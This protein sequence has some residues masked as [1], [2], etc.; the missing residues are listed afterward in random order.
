MPL[1]NSQYDSIRRKYE[2]RQA[3]NRRIMEERRAFVYEHVTGYKELDESV[4]SVSM[5]MGRKKLNGDDNALE[6]LH[7]LLE[8]LK[9]M[10]K[11][12]LKGA[13]LPEDYLTP[14]YACPDCKDT[15]YINGAK[16]HCFCQEIINLLYQQSNIRDLLVDNNFNNLSLKY[17]EG[18]DLD[19][20][21]AAA[22]ASKDMCEHF[23]EGPHNMMFYGTVGTGK[24]FLSGCIAGEV[25]KQGASVLYYSALSLFETIASQAFEHKSHEDLYNFYD[26]LYNCDLL[27]IDDLGTETTNS[28]VSSQLF[29]CINERALRKKS[30]IISTNLSLE[31]I[32]DRYSDRVFSRLVSGYSVYKLSGRDIR[33]YKKQQLNA[34]K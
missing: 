20:F 9:D 5:D 23:F 25:L 19:R 24:S 2:E 7:A 13:G 27:I 8:D 14:V 11:G 33:T 3:T 21:K 15:G 29:A 31:E 26:S 1:T 30:T 16:C 6:E 10:K 22:S 4:V 32:R 12:L 28:F 17:Y 18:E 34:R